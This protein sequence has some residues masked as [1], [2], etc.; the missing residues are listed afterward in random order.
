MHIGKTFENFH[1]NPLHNM[2][3]FDRYCAAARWLDVGYIFQ[4]YTDMFTFSMQIDPEPWSL[5]IEEA[6]QVM[7][8]A[9]PLEGDPALSLWIAINSLHLIPQGESTIQVEEVEKE[10]PAVPIKLLLPFL[11]LFSA[12]TGNACLTWDDDI[13]PLLVLSALVQFLSI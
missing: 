3:L 9:P 13:P 2:I 8:H 4:N 6:E 10:E 5:L 11:H 1:E 7:L 12:C